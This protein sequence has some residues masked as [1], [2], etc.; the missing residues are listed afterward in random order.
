MDERSIFMGALDRNAPTERA[1]YLDEACGGDAALRRRVDALLRSH[2]EAGD[3]LIKPV[4]ERLSEALT[5]HEEPVNLLDDPDRTTSGGELSFLSASSRTDSLGRLA[6][7]EVLELVGRGSM[8]LVL[9]VFDESLHRIVAI[10]VMTPQLANSATARRRFVREARAAAAVR[11]EHVV[12]IHAVEELHGL[13]YLVMEYVAGVSLQEMLDTAGPLEIREILRI[14][15]QAAEGLAA[16]HAQGLIHRDVKPANILLENGVARVKLTDFGL[17]RA[18]D[19]A[20]LT[21]SGIIAGTPLYMAPEQANAEPVDHRADLFSLGS[22]LYAMC[23]G[24]SPFRASNIM[25]VLKRVCEDTPRPIREINPEVPDWLVQIIAKLHAKAAEDR[26]QSAAEVAEL[27]AAHLADYQQPAPASPRFAVPRRRLALLTRRRWALAATLLLLLLAGIGL[28]E[29]TGVT[30]LTSTVLRILTPAGTLF[31]E[32]DDPSIKITVEG[33]GGLVIT[34][35]G[36]QEVRLRPGIYHVQA[37]KDGKPIKNEVVSIARGDKQ[38]VRVMLEDAVAARSTFRFIPPPPGPLDRLDPARIPAEERFP[39]QPKELVR[40]LGEHR[41]RHW[42]D[43]PSVAFS[44]DGKLIASG[45]ADSAIRLWDAGTLRERSLLLGHQR[46]VSSVAFSRDGRYLLS[47]GEDRTLRLWDVAAGKQLRRFDG[48]IA[49]VTTGVTLSR[50]GRRALSG[51]WDGDNSVRLWD[52]A[53]GNELLRCTGHTAGVR[54]VAISADGRRALSGGND[55][56]VRLWDLETGNELRCFKGHTTPVTSVALSPDGRLALSAGRWGDLA[57]R[58]WEVETGRELRKFEGHSDTL[59]YVVFSPDGRRA[60]SGGAG[61][62]IRLW[63]VAS[64]TELRRLEKGIRGGWSAA[65][66]PDG[67]RAVSAGDTLRLWDLETGAD[68]CPLQGH[69]TRARS[70]AFSPDGRHVLS[71]SD[72]D[73]VMRLWDVES[74]REVRRFEGHTAWV[75]DVAFSPDGR[76]ALSGGADHTVRLWEVATAKELLCLEGHAQNVNSVAFAPDGRQV[77]SGGDG[78]R[79]WDPTE[80]RALRHFDGPEKEIWSTAFSPD[81]RRVLSGGED[82]MV[83]LWDAASGLE[84]RCFAG[85]TE[86]VRQVAFTPDGRHA[87]SSSM[88]GTVRLWN[89]DAAEPRQRIFPRKHPYGVTVLAAAP[90][91]K[92]AVSSGA[93]GRVILWEVAS[94]SSLR[95]WQLPG[96]VFG[97]AFAHDGRHLATANGNGTVYIL[98]LSKP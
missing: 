94:A 19:D 61:S 7:Y 88:D 46:F 84:L 28:G 11:N 50:D 57:V 58:L 22:V 83:R 49:V 45:G 1:A 16:A 86:G 5:D 69:P 82:R 33:D 56:T 24:R 44:P 54:S 68:L 9:K 15:L 25:A 32:V 77:L 14:G 76:R 90:D 35:A 62:T 67:R 3:F 30:R 74:G 71:A 95:Q 42:L 20:S 18:A 81:G 48:H 93:D 87:F 98:R 47:G 37:A 12:G 79:H 64:G 6:H 2:A 41:G 26:F 97:A 92:T 34:G 51:G 21:Q 36:P 89:L 27:L 8:G 65:F 60:L 55:H 96:P 72:H 73:R 17:A 31:V 66:S 23:V 10:K 91:G 43:T 13:P 53:T 85:H 4:P 75:H 80:R 52:V 78:T 40:V 29:A 59:L 70:V 38:V 63:D 39:W